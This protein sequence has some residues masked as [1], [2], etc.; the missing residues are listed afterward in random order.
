VT[1]RPINPQRIHR[2]VLLDEDSYATVLLVLFVD[3]YGL[4]AV[5]WHPETMRM[6]IEADFGIELPKHALDKLMAAIAVITTNYFYRDLP[7]FI[8]LAN[9]LAGDDFDPSVFDPADSAEV[10]WGVSEA[11]LLSPPEGEEWFDEEIREYVTEMLLSEGYIKPPKVLKTVASVDFEEKTDMGGFEDD[12]EMFQA[13]HQSQTEKADDIDALMR[14][15]MQELMAQ[16][17][18]LPLRN[19]QT[20]NMVRRLKEGM[21]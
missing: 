6:Q 9:I 19:G 3:K 17:E 5:E 7:R 14:D 8:E 1:R 18:A 2:Q 21:K 13:I 10:A 15:N 20:S 12:P 11:L 16:L 4:E